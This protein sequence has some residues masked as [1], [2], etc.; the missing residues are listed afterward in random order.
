MINTSGGGE[1]IVRLHGSLFSL[2]FYFCCSSFLATLTTT[3][4][5]SMISKV[6]PPRKQRYS[7]IVFGKRENTIC[8]NS[9]QTVILKM[10]GREKVRCFGSSF[11]RQKNFET[12]AESEG[13]KLWVCRIIPMVV[14]V[15]GGVGQKGE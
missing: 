11:A 8:M 9:L 15:L 3:V 12:L 4:K 13:R 5:L 6:P 2:C 1:C 14:V 7:I 10:G